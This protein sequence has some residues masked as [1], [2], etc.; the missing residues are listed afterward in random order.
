M[1]TDYEKYRGKCKEYCQELAITNPS[2]EI[3]RGYFYE[4]FWR[5]KEPHWWCKTPEGDIID[6]TVKQ[7]PS[8][9]LALITPEF[10]YEEFD[11]MC[12]CAECGK[13][14]PEEEARFD[15]RYAFCSTKCNM[16]FVGL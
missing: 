3:V 11:G 12:E 1:T 4:P 6:P 10:F 15:S 7:F 13:V 5:E 2:L 9:Q 8:W 14:I 16:R